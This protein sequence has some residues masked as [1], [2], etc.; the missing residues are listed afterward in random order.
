[1][2]VRLEN[3]KEVVQT[4]YIFLRMKNAGRKVKLIKEAEHKSE[5]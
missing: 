4:K 3:G 5:L 2:L 1:V